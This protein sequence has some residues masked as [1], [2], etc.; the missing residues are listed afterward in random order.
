MSKRSKALR[1]YRSYRPEGPLK[2]T[3]YF[4]LRFLLVIFLLY[5]VISVCAL[6][7]YTADLP[8]MQNARF[9]AS[10]LLFGPEI[11]L[12]GYRFPRISTPSRGDLVL[13]ETG[14][15]PELPWYALAVNSL[16][17]FF[18][19]NKFA[20][21]SEGTDYLGTR[22]QLM[23]VIGVPGDRVV[24]E[25][26]RARIRPEGET[27]FI[28]EF[29]LIDRRY[30][31]GIPKQGDMIDHRVPFSGKQPELSLGEGEY[32]L[33]GDDRSAAASS[34]GWLVLEEEQVRARALFAFW[35]RFRFF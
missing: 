18:T 32:L 8:G 13:A 24:L 16:T 30:E 31:L 35:P 4:I 9:V 10:P 19:L 25:N 26:F 7:S 17:R 1:Y 14:R 27:R 28:D 20:A 6:Q 3:L 29:D 11:R 15:G 33:L 5:Q 2:K 21:F 22:L 12:I 34:S 23:R